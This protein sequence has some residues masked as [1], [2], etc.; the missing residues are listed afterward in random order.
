MTK[1][2]MWKSCL[3]LYLKVLNA[4]LHRT[5]FEESLWSIIGNHAPAFAARHDAIHISRRLST[6]KVLAFPIGQIL[7]HYVWREDKDLKA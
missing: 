1:C 7:L 6:L 5:P 2:A 3:S 4:L